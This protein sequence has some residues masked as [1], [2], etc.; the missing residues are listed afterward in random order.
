MSVHVTSAVWKSSKATG[1][2]LLVLLSLADQAD[3]DGFCWPSVANICARTRLSRAS[4]FRHLAELESLG[5]I[6]RASND[7]RSTDYRVILG[8][9]PSQTETPTESP[10][11]R[12]KNATRRT[13]DSAE[14]KVK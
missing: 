9:D 4:V 10:R 5:E 14:L 12:R 13:R 11:T 2:A 6:T 7:G 8:I 3:D 1:S